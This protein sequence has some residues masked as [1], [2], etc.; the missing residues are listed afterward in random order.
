MRPARAAATEGPTS[1][2]GR[3]DAIT[4]I[5]VEKAFGRHRVLR[6]VDLGIPEGQI[7]VIMGPS[8]AGK[9]VCV[10][11][12]VGLLHPDSG[13]VLLGDRSLPR[14]SADELTRTREQLSVMLQGSTLFGCGLFGSMSVY[15][16]V[17]FAL[18]RSGVESEERIREL[19]ELRLREVGLTDCVGRSPDELS[20]GM[21]RRAAL[22]RALAPEVPLVVL[23]DFETGIDGVRVN[24]LCDLVR[25]VHEE[26]GGTF[27]VT[28]HSIEVARRIADRV[29]LLW[30]GRIVAFG[31][32]E[33]LLAEDDDFVRQFMQGS[34]DGPLKLRSHPSERVEPQP[35]RRYGLDP[36]PLL[37]VAALVVLAVTLFALVVPLK[38]I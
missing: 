35:S 30:R 22:A 5:D 8:G 32:P 37:A 14:M 28:T 13:D 11:H 4:F 24:L 29:A 1:R 25:R 15:E 6:G 16:N 21:R 31:S 7:T 2:A 34:K 23:D 36:L 18:R 33:E 20:G 3:A 27:V 10:K 19:A 9:T 12:M 38:G 17:A 26:R